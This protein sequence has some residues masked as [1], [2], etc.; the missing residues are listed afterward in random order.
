VFFRTE[1]MP[2]YRTGVAG[3]VTLR[4][5]A[6]RRLTQIESHERLVLD[7]SRDSARH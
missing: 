1:A 3:I 6:L 5:D 4:R 2:R 7:P